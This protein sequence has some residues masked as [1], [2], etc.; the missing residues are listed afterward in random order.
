MNAKRKVLDITLQ[1]IQEIDWKGDLLSQLRTLIEKKRVHKEIEIEFDGMLV[2][3]V[4]KEK[5]TDY[6]EFDES[7]FK[8]LKGWEVPVGMSRKGL[9]IHD[10]EK[11]AHSLIGGST[12][13]GKSNILKLWIT[14]LIHRKPEDVRF[15]LLDLKGGLSFSRFRNVRQVDSVSKSPKEALVALQCVQEYMNDTFSY[16][17][18]NGFEDVKEAGMKMRHFIVIDEAADIASHDDCVE[19]IRRCSQTRQGGRSSVA[20]CESI[21][22]DTD[23]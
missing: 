15:T 6:I 13:F 18:S 11:I 14:T 1:D 7:L 16:L 23:H 2:F 8:R 19:L 12:D 17:E 22:N 5:L 20:V 4:Y 21:S 3:R 9:V 10:F